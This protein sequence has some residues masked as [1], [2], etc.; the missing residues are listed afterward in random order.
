MFG[1][2]SASELFQNIIK[3]ILAEI[4]GTLNI[5]DD[6][7]LYGKDQQDHD[8]NLVQ[9]LKRVSEN[10]LTLN[11]A[12]CVFNKQRLVYNGNVYSA[13]GVSPDPKKI[14]AI[15][16]FPSPSNA[17]EVRTLL[18][19]AT[20]CSRFIKNF[21]SISA[22]LRDLT[23]KTTEFIWTDE[24]ESAKQQIRE[25]LSNASS[26][27]YFDPDKTTELV[28]DASPVGYYRRKNHQTVSLIS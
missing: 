1:I 6:I 11:K 13:E 12:K 9:T 4:P 3:Q 25:S 14:S 24:H 22:P 10:N 18:V 17:S 2:S 5:S 20:Y 21:A 7:L 28:C 16:D 19:M 8:I 26:L 27:S 23:K 15:K